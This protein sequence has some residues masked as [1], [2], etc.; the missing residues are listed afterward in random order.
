MKIKAILISLIL[1]LLMLYFFSE[2]DGFDLSILFTIWG[3]I[4]GIVYFHL[5]SVQKHPSN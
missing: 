3:S 4:T 2:D 5:S 1:G